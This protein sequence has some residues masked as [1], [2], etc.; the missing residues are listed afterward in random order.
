MD[1]SLLKA[2]IGVVVISLALVFLPLG[3]YRP[4]RVSSG[5]PLGVFDVLGWAGLGGAAVLILLL[6][7]YAFR[8]GRKYL[9]FFNFV[10]V[11]TVFLPGLMLILLSQAHASSGEPATSAARIAFGAGFWLFLLGIVFIQSTLPKPGV[12]MLLTFVLMILPAAAGWTAQLAIF[13]EFLNLQATFYSELQRHLLLALSSATL[14]IIPGISLGFVCHRYPRPREWVL[15]FVNF[16]QIAPTLTLLG[17]MMI[18]LTALALR[19][20]LLADL[21]IRGIGFAPAFIVLFL[22][23]LLPITANAYAGFDQVDEDVVLSAAAMGMRPSAIFWRVK[24]PLA[25]P[26]IM[27]GIRTAVTQNLGNT[28]L[29]GLIGGGGMGAL[30]FLGLSQSA[31]DMV[32]LGTIPVVMLAL[33]SDAAFKLIERRLSI[34]IGVQHDTAQ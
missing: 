28:I 12:Y 29:A 23:C 9:A 19:F 7:I 4:N 8:Q 24:L 25:L 5:L 2:K 27:S 14:S 1:K 3:I 32:I 34:K 26:V 17:L 11:I 31:V 13:K 22:Y 16:F 21:G 6:A 30:I 15:G 10:A 33:L 18:P 20:P